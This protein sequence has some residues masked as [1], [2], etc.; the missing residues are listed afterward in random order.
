MKKK[1]Q[2][3]ITRNFK[4]NNGLTSKHLKKKS[5]YNLSPVRKIAPVQTKKNVKLPSDEALCHLFNRFNNFYFEG[6]LKE[7]RIEYSNRMS[8]A[9]SYCPEDKMIKLSTKYHQLFPGEIEDTLKHEMIHIKH[10][11]HDAAFRAEA[12]RIGASLKA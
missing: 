6:K 3:V 8:C 10:F 9:G 2:K 11:F 12:K 5:S 7:V 1:Q 4:S